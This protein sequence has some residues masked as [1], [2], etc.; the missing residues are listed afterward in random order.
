MEQKISYMKGFTH[1]LFTGGFDRWILKIVEIAETA[2]L[3]RMMGNKAKPEYY[4]TLG[5]A[6]SCLL[7]MAIGLNIIRNIKAAYQLTDYGGKCILEEIN[8]F[9]KSLDQIKDG[10]K[11]KEIL[12][13]EFIEIFIVDKNKQ[14]DENRKDNP[15]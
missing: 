5:R 14:Q 8:L 12:D 11:I 1:H 3:S 13:P 4:L 6:V 2:A 15:R 9:Y 10:D 7:T